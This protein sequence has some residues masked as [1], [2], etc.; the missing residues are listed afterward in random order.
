MPNGLR[1]RENYATATEAESVRNDYARKATPALATDHRPVVTWLS[2]EKV[3]RCEQLVTMIGDRDP[4]DA[5]RALLD[6]EPAAGDTRPIQPLIVGFLLHKKATTGDVTYTSHKNKITQFQRETGIRTLNEFNLKLAESW[7]N[8]PGIMSRTQIK[9]RATLTNFV[10]WLSNPKRKLVPSTLL[11]GLDEIKAGGEPPRRLTVAQVRA[12]I[13]A[14]IADAAIER[15]TK[16][17]VRMIHNYALR[18]FAGLRP[19]E[20]LDLAAHP[21]RINLEEGYV[22]VGDPA[23]RTHRA[24][25]LTESARAWLTW[26][27]ENAPEIVFKPRIH[28]RV[29]AAAGVVDIWQPDICRHTFG[30]FHLRRCRDDRVTAD[31]MGNFVRVVR[32]FYAVPLTDAELAAFDAL[33][34][35]GWCWATHL[36]KNFAERTLVAVRY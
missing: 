5:G 23:T 28:E 16:R 25:K 19:S 7:I 35:D 3:R 30:S 31:D 34:P 24:V 12:V 2:A 36:S 1:I 18:T 22:F 11:D 6:R 13:D 21:E 32:G 10:T 20:V 27:R 9:R 14:A 29:K 26:C 15:G 17:P 8:A 33:L 4:V